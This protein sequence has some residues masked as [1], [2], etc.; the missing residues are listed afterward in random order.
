MNHINGVSVQVQT[1]D[2]QSLENDFSPYCDRGLRCH[3]RHA[4]AGAKVFLQEAKFTEWSGSDCNCDCVRKVF[5][6][7]E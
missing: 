3:Q 1:I 4:H 5:L 6:I 7:V 2:T